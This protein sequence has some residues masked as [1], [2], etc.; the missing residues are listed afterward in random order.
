LARLL[1]DASAIRKN[2][3]GKRVKRRFFGRLTGK[4]LRKITK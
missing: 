2:K 3:V 4:L 1:G